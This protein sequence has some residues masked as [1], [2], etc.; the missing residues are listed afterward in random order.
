MTQTDRCT[1]KPDEH[2][3]LGAI[4]LLLDHPEF[5]S[6]MEC[7]LEHCFATDVSKH[8]VRAQELAHFLI[9]AMIE[10]G[11]EKEPASDEFRAG[12]CFGWILGRLHPKLPN[13]PEQISWIEALAM[14]YSS[15]CS[16]L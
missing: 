11:Q 9:E 14:Q 8:S 2:L 7:G 12:L 15:T 1:K 13:A 6:G 3:T 16:T 4:V 5:V 10:E